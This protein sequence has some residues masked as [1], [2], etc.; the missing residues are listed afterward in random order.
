M[1]HISATRGANIRGAE[2]PRGRCPGDCPHTLRH[3]CLARAGLKSKSA[4]GSSSVSKV[5]LA[6]PFSLALSHQSWTA[7][8]LALMTR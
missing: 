5:S 7:A 8:Q 2:C 3:Y 6:S 1:I 4:A